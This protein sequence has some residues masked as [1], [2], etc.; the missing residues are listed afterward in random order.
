MTQSPAPPSPT[1]RRLIRVAI[2]VLAVGIACTIVQLTAN[3]SYDDALI[4]FESAAADAEKG[5]SL[6]V[7]DLGT[8]EN[9]IDAA[10]SIT[11][12]ASGNLMD[13]SLKE[14]LADA[15]SAAET[16]TDRLARAA[17]KRIPQITAKP[18]WPWELWG[19]TA[20]LNADR[21]TAAQLVKNF[22]SAGED[23]VTALSTVQ[24]AGSPALTSA[25][26][27]AE[28]FEADHISARNPDIVALR[29]AA[30]RVLDAVDTLDSAASA[31]YSDLETAVT[32]MLASE[33]AELLEKAGP[34]N[35]ARFEVETFARSLAPGLLL[36]FDWS[37]LV[38]GFGYSDSMGGY[39]TWWYGDPGY[40]NID[41]SNSVAQ[42]WPGD[43]SKALVAHEV[44]HAISVRCDGMYDDSSQ[45]NIEDWATAWAISMG[46]INSSNGTATYGAPSQALIDAAAGCR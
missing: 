29:S 19:A 38:N 22:V 27:A 45:E 4:R 2:G 15:V 10:S 5:H 44:G 8:L 6:L 25:A 41:L 7:D 17:E 28:Q 26:D 18:E 24:E 36:D 37:P 21:E 11:E 34:L 12:D 46:F 30:G 9:A 16:R 33:H 1:G 39:A 14:A 3:L 43:R 31:A 40:A 23:A 32:Q 42:Y 13:A 35:D 20:R